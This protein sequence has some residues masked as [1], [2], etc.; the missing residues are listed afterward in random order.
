MALY[1]QFVEP[2]FDVS[3]IPRQSSFYRKNSH[4]LSQ[5]GVQPSPTFL[6]PNHTVQA[7]ESLL[8]SR[9]SDDGK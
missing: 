1:G 7:N 4:L 3:N 5:L 8:V 6:A 2:L 9:L